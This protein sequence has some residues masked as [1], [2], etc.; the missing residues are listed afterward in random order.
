MADIIKVEIYS[1]GERQYKMVYLDD[2]MLEV[3]I[4]QK[5]M[6]GYEVWYEPVL[7]YDTW[8]GDLS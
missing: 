1:E 3:T 4:Y 7:F 6:R 5:R 2:G 8:F